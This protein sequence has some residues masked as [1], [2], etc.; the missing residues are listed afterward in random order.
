MQD[1]ATWKREKLL[2]KKGS[3]SEVKEEGGQERKGKPGNEG[4]EDR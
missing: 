4:G 1:D 2:L 3:Q